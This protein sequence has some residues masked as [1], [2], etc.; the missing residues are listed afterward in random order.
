MTIARSLSMLVH[1]AAKAGKSSLLATAP[2]PRLILDVESSARFLPVAPIVWDDFGKA[3]PAFDESWDTVIAP[4]LTWKDAE[5][6]ARWLKS[7]PHPFKSVIIDSVS[8]LQQR[9]ITHVAGVNQLTQ[10]HWGDVFRTV[11]GYIRD[12]RDLTAHRE[13]PLAFMGMTAMTKQIEGM[14]KPW[15]NGQL[16]T[17]LPY[18]LDVT[19]YIWVEQERINK[20]DPQSPTV[21]VRKLLT[22]R[23]T[24]FEAG[25]RVG[26][27]LPAVIKLQERVDGANTDDIPRMIETIFT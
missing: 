19:G 5:D 24:Q 4:I 16:Q 2:P 7:S 13:R 3:P 10:Q 15:A 26:G 20:D 9:H 14:W 22:R 21:E 27:K 8:E 1:G 12:L 25:E 23:T 6:V 11:G 17:I 18:V